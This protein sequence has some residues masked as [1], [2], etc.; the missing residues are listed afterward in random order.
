M[1]RRIHKKKR[2]HKRRQA[3]RIVSLPE[4]LCEKPVVI[5]NSI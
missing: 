1:A 2:T 5:I 3:G 4:N